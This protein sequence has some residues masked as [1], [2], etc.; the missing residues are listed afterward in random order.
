ME[1]E[2]RVDAIY[3]D[4]IG[5]LPER[6]EKT[7]D[8]YLR[9]AEEK[10]EILTEF[11]KKPREFLSRDLK[12][13]V[14]ISDWPTDEKNRFFLRY[15][16]EPLPVI[17]EIYNPLELMVVEKGKGKRPFRLD[18]TRIVLE[19]YPNLYVP[20]VYRNF[21]GTNKERYNWDINRQILLSSLAIKAQ[22]SEISSR[23]IENIFLGKGNKISTPKDKR[24]FKKCV[25]YENFDRY[26]KY[27]AFAS[28]LATICTG[29]SLYLLAGFSVPSVFSLFD[30]YF[31]QGRKLNS[32]LKKCENEEFNPLYL[33]LRGN[34]EDYSLKGNIKDSILEL[35]VRGE[36]MNYRLGLD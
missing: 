6:N 24:C 35:G 28:L 32:F 22:S 14:K 18:D 16:T 30:A 31:H 3:Y 9:K 5:I 11:K 7:L 20:V 1:S 27:P 12:S 26:V 8:D 36:V 13:S 33:L 10:V 21:F 25:F 23:R 29:E 4:E 34:L 2:N 17:V 15:G 19:I